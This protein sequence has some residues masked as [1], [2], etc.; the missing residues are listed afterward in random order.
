MY[1]CFPMGE[2]AL[3]RLFFPSGC[4]LPC[5]SSIYDTLLIPA[6]RI[7]QHSEAVARFHGT[8]M[9]YADSMTIADFRVCLARVVRALVIAADP[10]MRESP[11]REPGGYST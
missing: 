10:S 4:P 6:I 8:F 11:A 2:R 3:F 9:K 1:R 7:T 5:Y